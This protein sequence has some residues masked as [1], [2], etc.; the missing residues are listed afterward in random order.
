LIITS[1]DPVARKKPGSPMQLRIALA[2]D[3]R[4]TQNLIL[5]VREA[6]KR[7]GLEIPDVQIQPLPRVGPKVKRTTGRKSK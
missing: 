3:Q 2:G 6:A 5:E 1:V 4:L 7:C